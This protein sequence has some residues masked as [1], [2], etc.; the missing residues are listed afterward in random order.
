ML[1]ENLSTDRWKGSG[2]FNGPSGLSMRRRS[3]SRKVTTEEGVH[4][5]DDYEKHT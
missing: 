2:N 3:F 4:D 1:R 5:R